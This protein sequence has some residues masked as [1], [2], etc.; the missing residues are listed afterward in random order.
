MGPVTVA[1]PVQWGSYLL[2][3]DNGETA[4]SYMFYAGYYYPE[5]GSDTPDTL[6]VALDKESYRS[7]RPPTSSSTRSSRA[8]R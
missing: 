2:E 8:P 7:A 5:V 1:A 3:V 4:S 6:Q